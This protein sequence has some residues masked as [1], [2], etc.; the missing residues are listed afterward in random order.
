MKANHFGKL[1]KVNG[2]LVPAT[3]KDEVIFNTFKDFLAEGDLVEIYL[4]KVHYDGTIPQLKKIHSMIEDL[5]INT[6]YSF[7]DMKVLVKEKAGLCLSRT[8]EGREYFLCKSFADCD[9]IQ[10]SAAIQA[11]IE[12]SITIGHPL[13]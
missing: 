1:K 7:E 9:K 10:L 3:Q 6:G 4:E 13:S 2:V 8:T 12:I 11:C 5:T